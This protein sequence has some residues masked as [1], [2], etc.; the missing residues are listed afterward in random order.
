[1][2]LKELLKK[3]KVSKRLKNIDAFKLNKNFNMSHKCEDKEKHSET[4]GSKLGGL[5][6]I[7]L[8]FCVI[9]RFAQLYSKM[10]HGLD[11]KY[12]AY[13]RANHLNNGDSEIDMKDKFYLRWI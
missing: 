1:M 5:L 2:A 12:S 8:A 7:F 9:A 4:I 6:T 11:D 10:I 13:K 3:Y